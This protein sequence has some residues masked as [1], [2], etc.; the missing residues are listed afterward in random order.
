M[1]FEIVQMWIWMLTLACAM[2]WGKFLS[3]QILNFLIYKVA[4]TSHSD[5]LWLLNKKM[6]YVQIGNAQWSVPISLTRSTSSDRVV[7]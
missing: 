2:I 6:Y 3:T 4:S 1:Y 5:E 7:L